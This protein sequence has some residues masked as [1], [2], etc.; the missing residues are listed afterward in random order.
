MTAK[1]KSGVSTKSAKA[2]S[3]YK[4]GPGKD[5]E[6]WLDDYVAQSSPELRPIA[7]AIRG[8][9]RKAV[10]KSHEVVNSWRIPAFDFHGPL[11][12]MMIGNHHVTICFPRGSW[13]KDSG[14]LLEGTGKNLRHVKVKSA[15]DLDITGLRELLQESAAL[16][17]ESPLGA[18]M[19]PKK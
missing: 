3:P 17:R 6:K 8:L 14:G 15:A 7:E 16:N 1:E 5:A 13:L 11:C 19:R 12:L 18:A 10:P 9:V 2:P 4:I